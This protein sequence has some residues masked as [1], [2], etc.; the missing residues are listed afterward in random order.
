V[1]PR[2]NMSTPS[3]VQEPF[4]DYCSPLK[5]WRQMYSYDPLVNITAEKQHLIVGGEV[6]MWTEQTDPVNL[7]GMIWPRAAAA[8]EVLWSG[9]KDAAG[10]NRS[11]IAAAPRLAEWRERLVNRGVAAGPVQPLWCTQED[12]PDSCA[13]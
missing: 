1:S 8:G 13:L 2:E 5:S 6:H 4:T 10:T 12:D 3:V 11:L 7:D 9:R